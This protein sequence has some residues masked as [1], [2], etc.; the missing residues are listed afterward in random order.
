M[1]IFK[2]LDQAVV[3]IIQLDHIG[4]PCIMFGTDLIQKIEIIHCF[5]KSSGEFVWFFI[6]T[7]FEFKPSIFE[8][9]CLPTENYCSPEHYFSGL[10]T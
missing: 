8:V 1:H 4:T 10:V 6:Q 9:I 7:I 2:E 3:E 5:D